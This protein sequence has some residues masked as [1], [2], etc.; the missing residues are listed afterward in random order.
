MTESAAR[1]QLLRQQ[2]MVDEL[3]KRR[4]DASFATK[5]DDRTIPGL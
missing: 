3:V 2:A 4:R 5:T 1:L